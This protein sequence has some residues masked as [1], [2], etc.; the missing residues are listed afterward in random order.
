MRFLTLLTLLLLISCSSVS[1]ERISNKQIIYF[2]VA[3]GKVQIM[4]KTYSS[5][6][7]K[8]LNSMLEQNTVA[9]ILPGHYKE[10]I[11]INAK[12][13]KDQPILINAFNKDVLI[14]GYQNPNADGGYCIQ[15]S[16]SS[17]ITLDGFKIRNCWPTVI[18]LKS[19]SYINIRNFNIEGARYVVEA[20]GNDN[21]YLTIENN[22]W[23]QDPTEKLWKKH[24]WAEAHHGKL[25]YFNGSILHSEAINDVLIK[26]NIIK[27]AYNGVRMEG[28]VNDIYTRNT[29]VEIVDNLFEN[30]RDNPIE[31]EHSAYNWWI[32]HNKIH[33]AHAWISLTGIA[34]GHI[35]IFGNI[36]WNDEPYGKKGDHS[37]GTV[38][39]FNETGPFPTMPVYIFHN[40]WHAQGNYL[41]PNNPSRNIIHFNNAIFLQ[42]KDAVTL[43]KNNFHESFQF[44]NDLINRPLSDFA[45]SKWKNY[46]ISDPEFTNVLTGDF[47]LKKGSPAIDSGK[48]FQLENW[49]SS[50]S[51]KAPD[52]GA[53]EGKEEFKG[54]K[55][56][57]R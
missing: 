25:E 51:G 16:S 43:T 37:G 21:K 20:Q 3:G 6:P 35:Y 57:R 4:G 45:K 8:S 10:K 34:G 38:L 31:P 22:Y 42:E 14:D 12:G 15:L 13:T 44:E 5:W 24:E 40:S 50:Y 46:I 30:I 2:S 52:I 18:R 32:H 39:K 11:E 56:F 26:S 36:G 49:K 23:N 55:Y 48:V 33:N 27:N 17:W 1:S 9:T 53:Y 28:G 54:P 41:L 19:S 47:T 7:I 29:N